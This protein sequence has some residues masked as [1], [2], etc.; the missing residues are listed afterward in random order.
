MSEDEIF[1]TGQAEIE[2]LLSRGVTDD[3][4]PGMLAWWKKLRQKYKKRIRNA[5][6]YAKNRDKRL[7][8]AREANARRCIK[9]EALSQEEKDTL[10]DNHKW[11]Q[12][13]YRKKNRGLLADKERERR[14]RKK[15]EAEA[16]HPSS[17][18][19]PFEHTTLCGSY[20][21][22]LEAAFLLKENLFSDMAGLRV[23]APH[24]AGS[25]E[26]SDSDSNEI[27]KY[28]AE[29][30]FPVAHQTYSNGRGDA[31]GL[32]MGANWES[33][34]RNFLESAICILRGPQNL[35]GRIYYRSH[36]GW[37]VLSLSQPPSGRA[38]GKEWL[39]RLFDRQAS[40]SGSFMDQQIMNQ[41]F[42]MAILAVFLVRDDIR[43]GYLHWDHPPAGSISL[44]DD[45]SDELWCKIQ[46]E[47][48]YTPNG[49][50]PTF[51][52]VEVE[53]RRVAILERFEILFEDLQR[54]QRTVMNLIT[55][56]D[57][58]VEPGQES[59]RGYLLTR[60]IEENKRRAALQEEFDR[61]EIV[62]KD[63]L[64]LTAVALEHAC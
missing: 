43:G 46:A 37:R 27:N 42:M 40:H 17:Y 48:T 22:P 62:V 52:G 63:L 12:Y 56:R 29:F 57:N 50:L 38:A 3:E 33:T 16:L 51:S 30:R 5:Q 7:P 23:M 14:M 45:T 41:Q 20:I 24:F 55:A 25:T 64:F 54:A 47:R 61:T 60:A 1:I 44:P 32:G 31:M 4:L 58:L 15:T 21:S 39:H 28:L 53:T 36:T 8:L 49:P 19:C 2:L 34:Q 59:D 6:N 13:C 10:K 26:S 11:S 35:I 18:V 9:Y